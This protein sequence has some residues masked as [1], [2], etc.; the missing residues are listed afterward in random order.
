MIETVQITNEQGVAMLARKEGH[1]MD[2]KAIEIKPSKLSET[3]S[4]F[5]NSSGGEL[6]IGIDQI[7][8]LDVKNFSWRGFQSPEDA[9]A[10]IQVFEELFPLGQYYSY[11]FLKHPTAPG[12]VLQIEVRKSRQMAF[13]SNNVAY[14]RRGAQNL[15]QDTPEKLDRLRM[16]KGI[17]S[18]ETDTVDATIDVVSEAEP[19]LSFLGTVIPTAQAEP[20]LKKQQLIKNG[21]P[22]VAAVL[23]FSD[24]PQAIL[25][26]RCGIKLYRYK[27]ANPVGSRETLAGDPLTIEGHL[28]LQIKNAVQETVK[29]VQGIRKLGTKGLEPISYPHEALHEILTNAVL[30]RDY[31]IASDIH[32]RIF[33]NRIEI[34]NPGKLPGHVTVHNILREQ[35]ARNCA[36]VRLINKFPDAP[37]KDVGEGLNTA[38]NAMSALRLKPPI[39]EELENAVSVHIRHE[40]LASPD[41]TVMAYLETHVEISNQTARQIT[42]ISSENSMKNVFYKLRNSKMIEQVPGRGGGSSAWRKK[43]NKISPPFTLTSN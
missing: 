40:L 25:P 42:G 17:V 20:W 35:F 8:I 39:I 37:N 11:T 38:F 3:I 16:D 34:E 6:F 10:H 21:K 18:F 2:F 30:H 5:A 33:D 26:K 19:L 13:A 15:P 28:Y 41:E 43:Q 9:N 22:T 1:F 32:I 14:L 31:S 27:T 36:M 7:E 12:Y 24:E 29:M 23:L 4:S